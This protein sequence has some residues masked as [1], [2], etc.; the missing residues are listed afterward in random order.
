MTF[1]LFSRWRPGRDVFEE[2]VMPHMPS[3]YRLAFHYCGQQSD[4][5]DLVQDLL[6]KLY[7][8]TRELQKVERLR[9][10]LA[11]SL[12]RMFIDNIRKAQRSPIE[13]CESET[14]AQ[15]ADTALHSDS[16]EKLVL[17]QNIEQAL[18]QL[19]EDQRI[20]V[21]MHD[22]ENYTLNELQ[23][24]L[25]TPVGTLKSRLHRA[26]AKLRKLLDD[27]GTISRSVAC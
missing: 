24:I 18:T 13:A 11:K 20:L 17:V 19:N 1:S 14:L 23:T 6:I 21:L 5:E 12:Y 3:L 27:D 9:P 7:P 15:M 26:R 16:T 10:W 2:L 22:V 4:A 25:D 8:K